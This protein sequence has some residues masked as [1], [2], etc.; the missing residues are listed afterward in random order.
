MLHL[1]IR[2]S[3]GARSQLVDV[4]NDANEGAET[5]V[6]STD[7]LAARLAELGAVYARPWRDLEG[8]GHYTAPIGGRAVR[9]TAND[10]HLFHLVGGGGDYAVP[11]GDVLQAQLEH[12]CAVT[13]AAVRKAGLQASQDWRTVDEWIQGYLTQRIAQ[14]R[15]ELDAKQATKEQAALQAAELL[16]AERARRREELKSDGAPLAP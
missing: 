9:I 3:H 16:D 5:P 11:V 13:D 15:S 7:W 14:A 2:L 8:Q 12:G 10:L 6:T 1:G 4:V